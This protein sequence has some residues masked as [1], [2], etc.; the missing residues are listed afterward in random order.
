MS[1]PTTF[2]PMPTA[3]MANP[4]G[5]YLRKASIE[6]TGKQIDKIPLLRQGFAEGSTVFVA[7]IDAAE[8][9][10]Q[11]EAVGGLADC[12]LQPNP[13]YSCPLCD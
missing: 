11:I 4:I 8:L 7:L 6:I 3:T 2:T 10:S 1:A 9:Q 13:S 5:S 12:R